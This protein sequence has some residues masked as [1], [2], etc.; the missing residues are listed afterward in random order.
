MITRYALIIF[1]LFFCTRI[2]LVTADTLN[3]VE[4]N[5]FVNSAV[6]DLVNEDVCDKNRESR[7]Y[8]PE[9]K[10]KIKWQGPGVNPGEELEIINVD[11]EKRGEL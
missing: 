2:S 3:I 5:R 6:N 10:S 8:L 4:N 7:P 1:L 9:S 11:R